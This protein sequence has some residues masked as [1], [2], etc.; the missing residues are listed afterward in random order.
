MPTPFFE[1][2]MLKSKIL[3]VDLKGQF[4]EKVCENITLNER[5]F[6]SFYC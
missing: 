5:L 2:K 6:S 4:Y 3:G 1:G